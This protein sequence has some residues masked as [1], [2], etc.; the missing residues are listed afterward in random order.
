MAAGVPLAEVAAASGF[1]DQSHLT[2]LF[3]RSF[4]ATPHAYLRAHG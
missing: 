1:A 4:G 2:R 3:A